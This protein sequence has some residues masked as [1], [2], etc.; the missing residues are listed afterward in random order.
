MTVPFTPAGYASV[1]PYLVVSGASDL[2]EFAKQTFQATEMQRMSMPDGS[3][4][5]AEIRIGDS[6]I[7]LADAS[8]VWP[9][10]SAM[11][12]VYVPDVDACY[13]RA[14][15]A[16]ASTVREPEDQFYGDRSAS[17]RDQS[18]IMWAIAT[19]VEDVSPEETERRAQAYAQQAG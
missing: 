15:A 5:H 4:M 17:V 11:L 18:G 16:G 9:A 14:L 2:I 6:V 7:M 19:H 8:P 13:A 12:H 10:L 1:T 3:L